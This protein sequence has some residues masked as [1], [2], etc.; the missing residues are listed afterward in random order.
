VIV[1][2]KLLVLATLGTLALAGCG[3]DKGT[4][5]RPPLSLPQ[6]S[7]FKTGTCATIADPVLALGR[8]THDRSGAQLTTED[9]AALVVQGEML[10]AAHANA[11]QELADQIM[12]VLMHIG[13]V[14]IRTGKQYDPKLLTD[15]ET[16]RTQ[17]QNSCTG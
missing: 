7:S 4:E 5:N 11:P 3:S 15:V 13:Y 10:L 17:L 16:A 14:R 1:M 12:D 8:F 2:K 9:R 6:A